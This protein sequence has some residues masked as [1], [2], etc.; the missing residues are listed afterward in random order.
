VW[1]NV[2]TS[3]GMAGKTSTAVCHL[4]ETA[5]QNCQDNSVSIHDRRRS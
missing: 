2:H 5:S 4:W 3:G 1:D